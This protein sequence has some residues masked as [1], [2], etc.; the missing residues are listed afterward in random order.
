MWGSG[1]GDFNSSST[2]ASNDGPCIWGAL[3]QQQEEDPAT[4]TATSNNPQERLESSP[5]KR[6]AVGDVSR[7][8][9][10][11][12]RIFD[13]RERR[14][15]ER[16]AKKRKQEENVLEGEDETAEGGN[17]DFNHTTLPTGREVNAAADSADF[18]PNDQTVS[19]RKSLQRQPSN[20]LDSLDASLTDLIPAEDLEEMMS[21]DFL[22]CGGTTS[23]K[24]RRDRGGEDNEV[25][26]IKSHDSREKEEGVKGRRR[27]S[28]STSRRRSARL[29][30]H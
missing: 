6:A 19:P 11:K 13:G 23:S 10:K 18:T 28:T 9:S 25:N 4:A 30:V 7:E 26:R 8:I 20:Y 16:E 15:E 27:E 22:F 24:G 12:P 5:H 3:E 21:E 14:L 2:S 29:S 1:V 17:G